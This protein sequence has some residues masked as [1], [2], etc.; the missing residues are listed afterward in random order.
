MPSTASHPKNFTEP[1]IREMTRAADEHRS[2]NPSQGFPDFDP[3]VELVAAANQADFDQ[4][5][6]CAL[7]Y[8]EIRN[9][10]IVICGFATTPA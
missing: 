10:T 3:P 9:P 2:I 6:H 7:V 5:H 4:L 1:V 8:L